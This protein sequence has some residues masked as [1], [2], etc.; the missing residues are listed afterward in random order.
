MLW[1]IVVVWQQLTKLLLFFEKN[2]KFSWFFAQNF[3]SLYAEKLCFQSL[4]TMYSRSQDYVFTRSK[5]RINTV[6]AQL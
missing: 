6:K 3:V 1:Q 2:R 5:L 4:N